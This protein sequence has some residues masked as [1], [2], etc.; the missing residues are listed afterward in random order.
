MALLSEGNKS[1]FG[2]DSVFFFF[3]PNLL[4]H[5]FP[6]AAHHDADFDDADDVMEVSFRFGLDFST[7]FRKRND[8]PRPEAAESSK[9]GITDPRALESLTWKREK[10][11]E[12]KRI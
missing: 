5:S 12:E 2:C 6:L 9:N 1:G 7:T 3:R 10:K 8:F 11:R 4:P